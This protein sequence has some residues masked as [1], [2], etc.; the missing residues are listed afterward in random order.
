MKRCESIFRC[1][2]RA[3]LVAVL[4]ALT[5]LPGTAA[6]M[7]ASDRQRQTRPE[8][9]ALPQLKIVL[10]THRLALGPIR[11]TSAG[12]T[13][14]LTNNLAV[15]YSLDPAKSAVTSTALLWQQGLLGPKQ[16]VQLSLA[17]SSQS[18]LL[19]LN[20]TT[21][22]AVALDEL[23]MG[24]DL[25]EVYLGLDVDPV[26]VLNA[27]PDLVA[28]AAELAGSTDYSAPIGDIEKILAAN[29]LPDKAAAIPG[30]CADIA[31]V[32]A[33]PKLLKEVAPLLATGLNA[34]GATNVTQGSV[35]TAMTQVG[36]VL[37]GLSRLIIG[38]RIGAMFL[39]FGKL[40]ADR[41]SSPDNNVYAP[42]IPMR[43][44]VSTPVSP[45]RPP[46]PVRRKGVITTVAGNGQ[47]GDQGLATQARL[48]PTGGMAVDTGG[49]LYIAEWTEV[50]QEV[51]AGSGIITTVAGNGQGGYSGDGGLAMQAELT[52]PEGVAV[53]GA[54]NVFIADLGNNRV[55]EVHAGS[56]I[57]TT[58]AGNGQAGFSGDGG[59]A[60]EAELN[61]PYGLAVD[62][63]GN[64]YIGDWDNNRVR[65]VHAGSGVITTAVGNGQRGYGGDGGP[66]TQ[67]ELSLSGSGVAV[68]SAGNLYVGDSVNHR[69]REV[70]AATGVIDTIAG[71][72]QAGFAGDDG[73]ATQAEVGQPESVAV[74]GAGNVYI[75]DYSNYRVREVHADSGIITTVAGN[76]VRGYSGDGGPASQAACLVEGVAVDS[77][78]NLYIA[79]GSGKR[80]REV[81]AGTGVI[82]SIAG[83]ESR[84][85]RGDGGSA[86][87]AELYY[88]TGIALDSAGDLLI[89]DSENSWVREVHAGTGIITRLA[90]SSEWGYSG[91][92]GPAVQAQ[93]D[94]PMGVAVDGAGDAFFAD[95]G[96][97]RVREV[98][99][100]SNT[101]SVVAG[102][103]QGPANGAPVGDGGPA[104]QAYVVEPLCV[105]VDNA[106]DLYIAEVTGRVREVHAGTGIIDAVAGS[107]KYGYSGDGGPA[108]QAELSIV[109]GVA[110][111][112]VGNLYIADSANNRV[113]EV[114]AGS[115]TIN[116][117]AGN[118]QA[119]FSGDGGPATQAEL[120]YPDGLQWIA[121]ATFSSRT[122]GTTGCGRCTQEAVSSAP[123]PALGS[124]A[125]PA[126]EGRQLGLR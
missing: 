48:L 12:F 57:I 32:L 106:G 49:N 101:V 78:G 113:R 46:Q 52:Q 124:R 126:M 22:R 84:G 42:L 123:W 55:R 38:G 97:N 110:V 104:I 76:G 74:D 60:T 75:D 125:M 99:A 27:S 14:T 121:P 29:S 65:E 93:L 98:N 23:V 67:A 80:V 120:N 40:I 118:G 35:T 11:S 30:L 90:G 41:L 63:A 61:L 59:P 115:G 58:V 114:P 112:A 117:V 9:L 82:T 68:D 111:D 100:R 25:V 17:G 72:G 87:R 8:S 13:F 44:T 95:T 69:V 28:V 5:V 3:V 53:D 92:G 103:G 6:A 39:D 37:N 19:Q 16:T 81:R 91:D 73:P 119:G 89:A 108:T 77:A 20:P 70:L 83:M 36:P 62:G 66:A 105:A 21:S 64:L 4:V 33:K 96:N 10:P 43:L 18:V 116:T 2:G 56:G 1:G 31:N 15:F 50:V 26:A 102:N 71:N 85:Y 109:S 7:Y 45:P 51:H 107:G 122:S 47:T 54:G 24:I 88:P 94:H 86:T 79:D 34:A